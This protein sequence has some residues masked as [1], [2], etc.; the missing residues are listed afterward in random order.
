MINP[1]KSNINEVIN[2]K[3]NSD[4][5]SKNAFEIIITAF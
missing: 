2:T 4:I 5:K 1:I 3:T